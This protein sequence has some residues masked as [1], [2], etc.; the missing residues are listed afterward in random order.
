MSESA[1]GWTRARLAGGAIQN[2]AERARPLV[3]GKPEPEQVRRY[4]HIR[5]ALMATPLDVG[6]RGSLSDSTWVTN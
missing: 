6:L 2:E 5:T 1:L 4:S 3:S